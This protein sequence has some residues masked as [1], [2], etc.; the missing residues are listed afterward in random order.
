M[1]SR[2]AVSV[3]VLVSTLPSTT[4]AE[5]PSLSIE[6]A[7]VAAPGEYSFAISG[8]G[9]TARTIYLLPCVVP[10]SGL[11]ADVDPDACD[12]SDFTPV[13]PRNG[14]FSVVLTLE[15]GEDGFA[16]GAGDTARTEYAAAVVLL[17]PVPGEQALAET[18]AFTLTIVVLS[19]ALIALGTVALWW[20]RR[21][22]ARVT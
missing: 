12:T 3:A 8:E 10:M 22:P 11:A 6:P 19:G 18:G 4:S 21:R 14:S 5:G 15:V 17:G 13:A 9:F 7:V 2:F 16:L 1:W 20:S